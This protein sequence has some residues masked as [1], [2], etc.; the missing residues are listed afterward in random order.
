MGDSGN[1]MR[2]DLP[3]GFHLRR[4]NHASFHAGACLMEAVAYVAGEQHSDRPN[5]VCP[6]L[7]V[8]GRW[9]NDI[10]NEGGREMLIPLIE[11]LIGTRSEVGGDIRNQRALIMVDAVV[12]EVLP[13]GLET[14]FAHPQRIIDRYGQIVRLVRVLNWR[15]FASKLRALPPIISRASAVTADVAIVDVHEEVARAGWCSRVHFDATFHAFKAVRETL[16]VVDDS[17]GA[18]SRPT[19][20][21]ELSMEVVEDAIHLTEGDAPRSGAILTAALGAY[22]R[23]IS[24]SE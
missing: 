19:A 8:I 11:R 22:W 15:G 16:A 10:M 17:V 24:F 9:L 4:G 23:A 7:G 6:V 5:C 12:R 14:M 21:A 2:R 3:P 18:W 1:L 13:L 20:I